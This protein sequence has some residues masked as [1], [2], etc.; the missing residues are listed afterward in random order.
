MSDKIIVDSTIHFG[1]P[2]I[3]GT[4][5]TVE[6]VLELLSEGISTQEILKNYY[7]DLQEEDIRACVRYAYDLISSEEIHLSGSS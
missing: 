7:P 3:A 6:S 2:C 4:R 5:I 1:K